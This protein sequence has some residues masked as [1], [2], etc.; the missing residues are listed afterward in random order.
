MGK[1]RL[2]ELLVETGLLTEEN[3]TRRSGR[4]ESSGRNAV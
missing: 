2:G 4:F 1:K 3:I